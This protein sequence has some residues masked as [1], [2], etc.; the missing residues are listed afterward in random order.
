MAKGKDDYKVIV[1]YVN[2]ETEEDHQRYERGLLVFAETILAVA[3]RDHK[4][5]V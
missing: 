2:R 5:A 4:E 1:R 3:K